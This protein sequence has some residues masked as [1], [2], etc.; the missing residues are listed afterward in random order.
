MMTMFDIESA[1]HTIMSSEE[2]K[3]VTQQRKRR[4]R[5]FYDMTFERAG[6]LPGSILQNREVL[7]PAVRVLKAPVG[8]GFPEYP[9]PPRFL[10]DKK[11]GRLPRDLE[12]FHDYWLVSD[13]MKSVLDLFC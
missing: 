2:M 6:G 10:F 3:S 7:M 4:K 8:R 13:R 1:S 11:Q 12:E 9:E 5:K